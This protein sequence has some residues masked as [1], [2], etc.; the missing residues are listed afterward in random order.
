MG[1]KHKCRLLQGDGCHCQLDSRRRSRRAACGDREFL[2]H[3]P[4]SPFA[5]KVPRLGFK[6]LAWRAV[7]QP[8]LE[9]IAVAER[10]HRRL[11]GIRCADRLISSA[12]PAA[13][14]AS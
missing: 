6:G 3:F 12:T 1:L 2:H 11:P 5:E 4:R 8:R 10:A 7:E 9:P 14:C 13:S